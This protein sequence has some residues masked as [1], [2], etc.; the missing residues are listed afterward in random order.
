M[1]C[2]VLSFCKKSG[3]TAFFSGQM[4]KR[5]WDFNFLFGAVGCSKAIER[6]FPLSAI[7][8]FC[9][10]VCR[11]HRAALWLFKNIEQ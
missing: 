7:L 6:W 4:V 3:R 2:K 9:V 5:W 11:F 1:Q 8:R 10:P